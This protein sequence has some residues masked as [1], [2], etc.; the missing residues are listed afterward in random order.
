MP[1]T[2]A[3]KVRAKYPGAYDDLSDQQLESSVRTKFPGVYDD[4]PLSTAT[5]AQPTTERTWGDTAK[6]NAIGLLKSGVGAFVNA[7]QLVHKIPGVSQAVDTLYGSPGVSQHAFTEAQETVR[8]TNTAQTIGKLAG[9][10]GQVVMTGGAITRAGTALA[11]RTAPTVGRFI[12][13]TAA[14]LAPRV[15]VEAA[16]GAGIAAIQ[17]GDPTTG[18]VLSGAMPIV[19]R[20][21]SAVAPALKASAK[22]G[23]VKALGP[24][25]ERFKALAEKIAPEVLKRGLR[26]SRE[27]LQAEA[28]EA[29]QEA[30]EHID[31]A[32]QQYGGRL[33]KTQPILEALETAKRKYIN[34]LAPA[35]EQAAE[36]VAPVAAQVAPDAVG[37]VVP[38]AAKLPAE[39]SADW[40]KPDDLFSHVLTDAKQQ[41]FTGSPGQLREMF[42]DAVK[43]AKDLQHEAATHGAGASPEGLLQAIA[44]LGGIGRKD[45]GT[46]RGQGGRIVTKSL[47]DIARGIWD[48][49]TAVRY[50]QKGG[51]V[52]HAAHMPQGAIGGI[53]SVVKH[54]G[55][56]LEDMVDA[57]AARGIVFER[58]NELAAAIDA[59]AIS[60]KRRKP[61]M[62]LGTALQAVGMRPGTAWWK[63]ADE[64]FDVAAMEP[65]AA[66]PAFTPVTRIVDQGAGIASTKGP[67]TWFSIG[68]LDEAAA[69]QLNDMYKSGKGQIERGYMP[70]SALSLAENQS[71]E[72]GN[73]I[74]NSSTEAARQFRRVIGS[75]AAPAAARIPREVI[76]DHRPVKQIGNLQRI[77]AEHGPEMTAAQLVG[78]RRVWDEVV[79][80]AGGYAHRAPGGIGVPLKDATEAWAKRKATTEIRKLLDQAVPELSAVNKEYAFWKSLDDVLTQTLK[81]TTPQGPSLRSTAAEGAGRLAGVMHGGAGVVGTVSNVWVL[82]KLTK[83]AEA[84]FTSPRWR[85]VSAHVK[86]DLAD[87]ITS[88]NLN[89]AASVLARIT[90]TQSAKIP[91][92]VGQ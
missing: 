76:L 68:H 29:V 77:L 32:I 47:D 1:D 59:A 24:T 72:F 50:T 79:A 18:A 70:T 81:R 28:G 12:G 92:A 27:A 89:K 42:D 4:I 48:Q 5:A 41:G 20:V 49:S 25:K 34:V 17:G 44:D 23:V 69:N 46:M 60:L 36:A 75:E 91:V 7:G 62:P 82:G 71:D 55:L 33:I 86:D 87:A 38:A 21:V 61:G 54:N 43:D 3:A 85:L 37:A 88:G 64:G 51:Q 35:E 26:G 13:Q 30:G 53:K 58:P 11:A 84:A 83:M 57:L 73:R 90:A 8:P 63:A 56:S 9:D 22:A 31:Q 74:A 67:E 78:V 52:T 14:Q 19:G 66:I 45:L 2:L 39:F 65:Q 80:Q 6:D 10:I 40:A 15:G 16:T